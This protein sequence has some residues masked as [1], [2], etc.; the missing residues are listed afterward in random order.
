[1]A[2]GV[3][4]HLCPAGSVQCVHV[5]YPQLRGMMPFAHGAETEI[6]GQVKVKNDFNQ[7]LIRII[8]TYC[9]LNRI[10][11]DIHFD[12]GIIVTGSHFSMTC[13]SP[14]SCARKLVI[15]FKVTIAQ[16]I[17][18]GIRM[19]FMAMIYALSFNKS[20]NNIYM[21]FKSVAAG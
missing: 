3:G 8:D 2:F 13:S 6:F 10:K 9:S 18:K 17:Q 4:K 19:W 12:H 1:M 16:C 20:H 7:A 15:W 5:A 21:C 11:I 14:S